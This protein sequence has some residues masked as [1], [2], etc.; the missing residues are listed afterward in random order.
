MIKTVNVRDPFPCWQ[1]HVE[2]DGAS[3]NLPFR[4]ITFITRLIV[5]LLLLAHGVLKAQ[6]CK[7]LVLF[8]ANN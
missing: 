7:M 1:G 2:L 5:P 4:Y 6:S 8:T 3:K